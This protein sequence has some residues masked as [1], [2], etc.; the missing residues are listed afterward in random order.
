MFYKE[1][2]IFNNFV[3]KFATKYIISKLLVHVRNSTLTSL[4]MIW[5][6]SLYRQ[7]RVTCKVNQSKAP[8]I[9]KV[10]IY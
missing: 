10:F 8:L 2:F 4:S 1:S 3:G 7:N 6:Q 9:L 5:V